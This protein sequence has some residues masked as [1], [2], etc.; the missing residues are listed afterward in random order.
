MKPVLV[1]DLPD[2]TAIVCPHC[3]RSITLPIDASHGMQPM[4]DHLNKTMFDAGWKWRGDER[5]GYWLC[6]ECG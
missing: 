5:K 6:P 3:K 2:T 1:P 4:V